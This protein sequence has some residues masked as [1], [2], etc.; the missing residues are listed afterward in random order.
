MLY[1][2]STMW[3]TWALHEPNGKTNRATHCQV[4]TQP[5]QGILC[6]LSSASACTLHMH[7]RLDMVCEETD[8]MFVAT[9][10]KSKNSTHFLEMGS[11]WYGCTFY[12]TV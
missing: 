1:A 3:K 10:Q 8:F 9:R 2:C 11:K 4:S 6:A 12:C 7:M 5:T